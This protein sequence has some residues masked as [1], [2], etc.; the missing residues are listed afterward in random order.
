MKIGIDMQALRWVPAAGLYYHVWH[1]FDAL[2]T[3]AAPH[4]I[5]PCLYGL[6]AIEELDQIRTLRAA[7]LHER[8]RY[9]WDG[10]A[11]R[12]GSDWFG[13]RLLSSPRF[14]RELDRRILFRLQRR[15]MR[16][17]GRGAAKLAD[18]DLFHHVEIVLFPPESFRTNVLTIPDLTSLRVPEL[19]DAANVEMMADVRDFAR[20]MDAI[21]TESEHTKADVVELLG[22]PSDRVHVTPLAAHSRYRRP[23]DAARTNEVL[24]RHGLAWKSYLLSVGTLEPRKNHAR[25]IEAYH[26]LKQSR[27]DLALPLILAG[28]KGWLYDGIAQLIERLGL[29]KDVRFLGYVPLDDLPYV[30][31]G[32]SA[33][34]Y[35][36]LYE[37][38]G[39][40]PLE[41]MSCGTAVIAS[42]TTSIPEVVGDAGI[43]VDPMSIDEIAKA[44]ESVLSNSGLRDRMEARSL[45]RAKN[46]SWERT[47]RATLRAYEAARAVSQGRNG[48][49]HTALPESHALRHLRENTETQ[50]EQAFG[51]RK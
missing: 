22:I 13:R 3:Y 49:T 46:F 20:R 40:P 50:L 39:L 19:H 26:R 24:A 8:L 23:N 6:P 11:Y 44:L 25:L 51:R 5:I 18:I 33:F 31:A 48:H 36:S 32:A 42:N 38:F 1:L 21:I 28:G 41:A 4:E 12:L 14:I 47:A 35:P 43:L 27:P 15:W 34:V 7:G 9:Y 37:G 45:E 16:F 2:R 30:M 17:R 29:Q 10:P